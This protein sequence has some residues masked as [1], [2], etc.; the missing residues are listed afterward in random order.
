MARRHASSKRAPILG[1]GDL[2]L[3][4]TGQSFPLRPRFLDLLERRLVAAQCLDA[5]AQLHQRLAP[6]LTT[7]RLGAPRR[8]F[9][10]DA[11]DR[12]LRSDTRTANRPT[13]S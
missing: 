13:L 3:A 12:A 6:R 7:L 5:L 10:L 2:L 9:L 8:L 1:V 11:I 4:G